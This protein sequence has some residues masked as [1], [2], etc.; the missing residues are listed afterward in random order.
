MIKRAT[1]ARNG[2]SL[3]TEQDYDRLTHLLGSLR[4]RTVPWSPATSLRGELD[5][6]RVVGPT[7][8]PREVVTMHSRV[9]VRDLKSDEAETYSLVYPDEADIDA[10]KLS[11]LA[12][13]GTALL[14]YR[15]GDVVE[16]PV[17]AGV[18]RFRVEDARRPRT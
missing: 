1:T 16:W 11:V 18:A 10:G 8:V 13:I 9:R 2:H 17:P 14:G 4:Y 12:P 7:S 3:F 15:A 5:R 6:G